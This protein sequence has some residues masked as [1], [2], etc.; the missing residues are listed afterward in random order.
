MANQVIHCQHT[1][2]KNRKEYKNWFVIALSGVSCGGKTTI[3]E[4][5]FRDLP[6]SRIYI[7]Q[8]EYILPNDYEGH[9]KAPEPLTGYNKD[10]LYSIDMNKMMAD[11]NY[12][13]MNDPAD[14]NIN[15]SLLSRDRKEV[16]GSA[17][18]SPRPP[19]CGFLGANSSSNVLILDG[20]LLLN[21]SVLPSLCDSMYFITLTK[22]Q[23][24][25]RRKSRVYT[26]PGMVAEDYFEYC[27]WPKYLQHY[28]EMCNVLKNITF[29]DGSRPMEDNFQYIFKDLLNNLG[30][31]EASIT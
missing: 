16:I 27:M 17:L 15:H 14:I 25:S 29:I 19:F 31:I 5:I 23:C 24:R 1:G 22:E 12:V 8:D 30:S 6:A 11:I 9:L 28:Q 4:K 13:L 26:S 20:F 3:A 10:S 7:S 18:R 2:I 21:H